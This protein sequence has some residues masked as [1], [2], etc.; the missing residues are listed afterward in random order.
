MRKALSESLVQLYATNRFIFLTGDLGFMA[1]EELRSVMGDDFINAGVAEQNMISMAAGMASEGFCCFVYS[2]APF[3]YARP[4]EQ[5]RNDV[6]FHGLPVK[7][8][9][10]GGGFGYGVMGS[11]HHALEDYGSLLTLPGMKAQV[12]SFREDVPEILRAALYDPSPAYIRLGMDE[13]PTGFTAPPFS[14]WRRLTDGKGPLVLAVGPLAGTACGAV[15][16]STLSVR[17]EIWAVSE[18]PITHESIPET[19]LSGIRNNR[20]VV[21]LEEH[22][23]QGSVG[24]LLALELL[25]HGLRPSRFTHLC[26]DKTLLERSGS[27]RYYREQTGIGKSAF[28]DVL[29]SAESRVSGVE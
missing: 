22:V 4:F 13:K 18:L 17:P 5:I 23:R 21:V 24:S 10:N 26:P 11:T 28:L 8:I 16:D 2:I 19:F 14:P 1:F 6:C 20:E 3:L 29:T 9:G 7:L 25:R 15:Q 27:Q 12:P